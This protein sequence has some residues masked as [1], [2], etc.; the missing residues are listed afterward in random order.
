MKNV[1]HMLPPTHKRFWSALEE[2][3]K[4]EKEAGKAWRYEADPFAVKREHEAA[5]AKQ[6][7]KREAAAEAAKNPGKSN[8][9]SQAPGGK[10]KGWM[11]VPVVDMAHERRRETEDI[12]RRYH[13][14]NP[15]G[16]EMKKPVQE[17]I[18]KEMVELSFRRAHAEEA[19]ERVKDREEALEWLLIH[20][21]ED[22]LPSRF[23]PENYAAGI[24]VST[25]EFGVEYAAKRLSVA[26]YSLDLCREVL[27]QNCFNEDRAAEALMQMLVYGVQ[28]SPQGPREEDP[29]ILTEREDDPWDQEQ[30]SL[31]AIYG[32]ERFTC[33]SPT[34]SRVSLDLHQQGPK[35]LPKIILEVRK[36][37]VYS[38]SAEYP[39]II[40]TF[41]IITEGERKLPAY[42]RLSII[43]QVAEYAEDLKGDQ[44]IFT[45]V[46]WLEN[47]IPR[48]VENPG[49]LMDVASAVTGSDERK[50]NPA[51]KQQ[52]R[53][54]H[55]GKKGPINWTP[56]TPESLNILRST[57]ER[58]KLPAQQKMLEA[59]QRL[60][61]WQLRADIVKAVNTAQVVII[62]GETGSG[63]STQSVQFVLDDLIQRKLGAFANIVCTQPR[64]ISALGLAD[65]VSEERNQTVGQEIGYAIRGESRQT[66]GITKV[67]FVTTGVLLRR[68]Q[69]GDML[70]DVS[71]IVV[72]E[73]HER[74]LD[75]DFLLIL[76][77]RI[78]ARRKDLKI[79]LMSATLDADVFAG[80]FGGDKHVQRINIEGRT[81]PVTDYYLDAVISRTGFTGGGRFGGGSGG[82]RVDDDDLD[83]VDSSVGMIIRG[84]GDRINYN[85]IAATVMHIDKQLGDADGAILIFLPGTMEI[86]RC[87]DT[88]RTLPS[89]SSRYHVLPLHASLHPT[90]QRKVFPPAPN[91][92]RKV[93]AATNVAETSI[94]IED[95]VCVIDTG[96]VKETSY[97]AQDNVVKLEE[98]WVSCAAAKQ[99]RGRA[100]RVRAGECYKLYTRATE[101]KKMPERPEPELKRVP[102]EQTCL[103]VKAMGIKDVRTFLAAAISPPDTIAVE[104]ALALL[105]KMGAVVDDELS[106]LGRH[107]ALIPADLRCSKLMVYGVLFGCLDPA[108]TIASILTAKSPFNSPMDKRE[109][110]QAAREKFSKNQGD[111]LADCRAWEQ[112]AEM[113]KTT[114]FRELRSW[115]DDNFLNHQTMLDI[116]SNRSQYIDSLRDTGF[117]P[118]SPARGGGTPSLAF[119]LSR[120]KD[121]DILIRALIAGAFTPQLARIQLPEQKF[122]SSST[123][124]LAIDPEAKTI[125][126]FTNDNGRVFVHPSSTVFKA[127]SFPGNA[128]FLAFFNKMAT[129]VNAY[130]LLL[131]GGKVE[132]DTLGRG[133]T[134]DGWIRLRGWGRI[135]ILVQ[136]LRAMLDNALDEMIDNPDPT[137]ALEGGNAEVVR[138]VIRLIEGDG[139]GV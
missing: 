67:T 23:I 82:R 99:R 60:P 13:V 128:G 28:K 6:E 38:G 21:P 25:G 92:L 81:F 129:T 111:L 42:V 59:R 139:T 62:S 7:K 73:V 97:N 66:H 109:E 17:R 95:V 4:Q 63:K 46:D 138:C 49:R 20:V 130:S 126:F 136:R 120:N 96:R 34:V 57:E 114:S 19:C 112:W 85:L 22:D 70:E 40:P 53:R 101:A 30:S 94:T 39:N 65:R 86:S 75:T 122:A 90:D 133:I 80:Y 24:T 52:R 132:V 88:I 54:K 74:S 48:I 45:V 15:L 77:K 107:M 41:V 108:V 104:G 89:G 78:I 71:H 131:F 2:I 83:G 14:W 69:T 29:N 103:G 98:V 44:M 125:K 116:A 12:I 8:N 123:G 9:P 47:E 36:P 118:F 16:I 76:I 100:G 55:R 105:E 119:E 110:S 72:D 84:L 135:G 127:Q 61:A 27:A 121:N 117:L 1:H 5:R 113:R 50:D 32:P 79:I 64:R 18:V 91:G 51:E 106:A 124:A 10:M 43:R 56:G 134:V 68:L 11:N 87:I 3:R 35:S 58:L 137:A 102:L 26:G 33:I 93:I 31:E 37:T 115:C